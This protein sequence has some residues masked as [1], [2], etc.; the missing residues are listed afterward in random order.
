MNT[1]ELTGAALDWA[2]ETLEIQR[3]RD[4]GVHVKEWWVKEKQ[5][6]PSPYSTDWLWS[7]PI[8]ER[9]HISVLWEASSPDGERW[10]AVIDLDEGD[11]M[12]E[13]Q[14]GETLLIAALRC[15]V[16]SNLGDEVAIPEE[17]R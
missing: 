17:L 15:Y 4:N 11:A 12:V 7:G 13:T 16:L 14:Y 6:N 5:T 1:L 10:A 9:E 2:V 8:I 3:M